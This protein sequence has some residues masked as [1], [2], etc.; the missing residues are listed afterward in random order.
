MITESGRQPPLQ[1]A[2]GNHM[3]IVWQPEIILLRRQAMGKPTRGN[4]AKKRH[5]LTSFYSFTYIFT[6][7][8]QNNCFKHKKHKL[9]EV[10]RENAIC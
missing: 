1:P 7:E 8:K 2:D 5:L 6:F 4:Q 10:E 9:V 3:P